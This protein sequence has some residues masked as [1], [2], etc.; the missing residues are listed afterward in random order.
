[1]L[2]HLTS[3]TIQVANLVSSRGNKA[4]VLHFERH[5]SLDLFRRITLD[6]FLQY[7]HFQSKPLMYL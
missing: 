5:K 4:R 2:H 1:M 7:L 3:A 6:F